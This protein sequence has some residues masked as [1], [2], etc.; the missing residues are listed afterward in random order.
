[1][2]NALK[3]LKRFPEEVKDGVGYALYQVQ[4][5]GIPI[6]AKPLKGLKPGVMEIVS[7]DCGNTYRTVYA[8]K[9]DKNI[10]VLHCFQKKSKT[11]IKTSKQM[12]ELI[13]QR[14]REA[15]RLS[16]HKKEEFQ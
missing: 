15:E 1:M 12:I 7:D 14:L 9:I 3:Q 4:Y 2:G 13:R 16:K 5:G 11:G 6:K 10:Y 8:V